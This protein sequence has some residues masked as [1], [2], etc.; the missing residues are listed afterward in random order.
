MTGE[1]PVLR[2]RRLSQPDARELTDSAGAD[3]VM[4]DEEPLPS[5][6]YGDLGLVVVAVTL[7]DRGVRTVAKYLS[8]RQQSHDQAVTASVELERPDGTRRRETVSYQAR[9]G[10]STVEAAAAAIRALPGVE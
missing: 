6:G 1:R 8:N 4:L 5:G 10:Q 9:P 7:T 3:A 2:L